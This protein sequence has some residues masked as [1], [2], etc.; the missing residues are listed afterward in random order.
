MS[1]THLHCHS[2]YSLL[3]SPFRLTDM[4]ALAKEQG[5]SAI[6]LTDNG[7]MYG[8][9]DFYLKAKEAGL[10][11]II[12][13]ELNVAADMRAKE[14]GFDK[15]VLLCKDYVG[16]QSLVQL[17]TKSH[18][19]GFYYKPRIDLACLEAHATGLIAIS[20]GL[21]GVV[22]YPLQRHQFDVATERANRLKGIFGSDFY[23]GI[24]RVGVSL[25]ETVNEHT[26]KLSTALGIEL[27]ATNDVY[28]AKAEH[29][30]LRQIVNCIQTGRR[31]EDDTRGQFLG[32]ESY[33]KSP[34]AMAEI[35]SDYPEALENAGKVADKCNVTLQTD[36]VHLPRFDCPDGLTVEAYMERLV[37]EGISR[38]YPGR[39]ESVRER[40]EFEM[41]VIMKM[42][43]APYFLI[44]YDFL[45]FCFKQGI[46]V[47][48]GRGSAA[49]SI[50]A[51][52]LNITNIDP[53]E[54]QLLFERFLNP[55]RVSM[56]DVDLDFCIR[57]RGEVIAYIVK[58]YGEACVSQI[59]TFGTMASRGVIRDVGRVLNVPLMEVDR[60]AKLIPSTPGQY[61]SIPEAMTQ[62]PE[63]QKL[64]DDSDEIR[65][66]LDIAIQ[67]EGVARH[68]STHAAGVVISRDP[69]STVVPLALNDG[70]ITTQYAMTELEKVGLL[71]MD[72]LGLRNLTVM[73]DACRL[74]ETYQG[75]KIDLN[76]LDVTDTKTYELLCTGETAGI[77]QLESRGMR[78]L[79]K[80]LHPTV[81]EDIIA[82]LALYRPGPLGSGMVSEF[83]SNKSGKTQVKYDLDILEPILKDTY[84]MIVYQ[85]QVMQIA[86]SVGG[87]SLGQADV[88]RR[89]MGKKKKS[90]MD[91]MADAFMSG[92]EEKGFDQG[93][94]KR[95]F[96][97]CYKFAE[98]GFN[99]SH[100]AAYALISFQ[101]AYLKAHY[102]VEYMAALLSSVLGVSDKTSLYIDVC[103]QMQMPVLPPSV[104]ESFSDYTVVGKSIR[105]GLGAIKNVGEGAIDSLVKER[106]AGAFKSLSDL[107]LRVDLRQVNKR[108]LESLIK[109]GA[110]DELGDRSKLL[111]TYEKV[112][113]QA[114][115]ILKERSNGQTSMFSQIGMGNGVQFVED[116]DDY[117]VLTNEERLRM[118]KELLGLYIS[119]HPLEAHRSRIEG[120]KFNLGKCT[121]EDDN[122]MVEMIGILSDCKRVM[123]KSKSEMLI[124]TM[125]DFK[126]DLRV[127][128]FHNDQFE[129]N[130]QLFK[131][132]H[133]VKVRGRL[134]ISEDEMSLRCDTISLLDSFVHQRQ[135]HI[136]AELLDNLALFEEF[137]RICR[138]HRG[139]IPVFFHVGDQT[140][141]AHKRFWVT[142]DAL[143]LGQVEGLFGTSCTWIATS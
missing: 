15:I 38:R 66:L 102:P 59:I 57:R 33:F 110:M 67:L 120:M 78:Q 43:Y 131:D 90:E 41:S 49:G 65:E 130:V 79:I 111:G 69:L 1:F 31:L 42:G 3:E 12:G 40:V 16:Y 116:T 103:R 112:L 97:L 73:Q 6:A 142:D 2:E 32:R 109:S 143:C 28:Y 75:V 88:L 93:K 81:F 9:I 7:V 72:I 10:K 89:A 4:V 48:P 123:T 14:R 27:V 23:L 34:E 106:Q 126:G 94:A 20:P 115:T 36:Q 98:Y 136:D 25:E 47:G 26:V 114:Q 121:P 84:G 68:S 96:E 24:Q 108:V 19:E 76:T 113:D 105:F 71:K 63:L 13:C 87:F 51:Y 74:I 22:G 86:S 56:P 64:Y 134:R 52:A 133:V 128:I 137:K 101:T 107:C 100:S 11:P 70:Q 39:E 80:D 132:D 92:A 140:V 55:E 85:E 82:L 46:P 35:F 83:V 5:L 104:N 18:L 119:G 29:A 124:G 139:A 61:T 99:K 95:I 17:V 125:T 45:D 129:E 58:K 127:L 44:I 60:I 37:K 118:E 141:L 8:V 50:V 138:G 21:N 30:P 54:Y 122:K 77:F 117:D 62:I 91:K 53:I 135:L